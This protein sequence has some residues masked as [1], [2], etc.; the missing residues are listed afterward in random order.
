MQAG[1]VGRGHLVDQVDI[2]GEQRRGAGTVIADEAIVHPAPGLGAAEVAIIARELGPIAR[3]VGDEAIGPG[4]DGRL[5]TVEIFGTGAF[6][7]V[8]GD[9]GDGGEFRRQQGM[10]PGRMKADGQGIDDLHL[11]DRAH[12]AA[13]AAGAAGH[14]RGA[15]DGEGNIL[16][17]EVAPVM[18]LHAR[19]QA[20][21]PDG[22]ADHAPALGKARIGLRRGIAFDQAIK[23]VHRQAVVRRGVVEMGIDGGH[24][25]ADAD[26]QR[27]ACLP[28]GRAGERGEREG[29]GGGQVAT[30]HR[31][32][33]PLAIS[34]LRPRRRSP[35]I[36][37]R[38]AE[39]RQHRRRPRQHLP[40]G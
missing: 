5:A 3:A 36:L 15:G 39:P 1:E 40:S 13:E 4:A 9:D 8:L 37:R 25:A 7:G 6:G 30:V 31:R 22:F 23:D 12:E 18:P 32:G 14:V 17:G 2:A 35:R 20:E 33:S 27:R 26:I 34:I 19:A 29:K 28:E 38:L 21:F 10:R 16:G 24:R 11:L